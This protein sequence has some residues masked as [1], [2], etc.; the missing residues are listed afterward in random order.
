VLELAESAEVTTPE[1]SLLT[2]ILQQNI[3]SGDD[4]QPPTIRRGVAKDRIVS[5]KD[6]EMRHGRKSSGSRYDGHKAHVAVDTESKVITAVETT[7]PGESDGAQVGK[8]LEETQR[9]TGLPVES[10]LGDCAYSSREAMR[11]AVE[12]GVDLKTRMPSSKSGCFGPEAFE[13]STDGRQARCPAGHG[14][15]RHSTISP[16]GGPGIQHRWSQATCTACPLKERCTSGKSR[17]LFVPPDFHEKRQREAH[18]RS[19]EGLK[20]LRLRVAAEHA[21]ARIKNRGAGLARYFGREKTRAQWLWTAAIANLT[22][23]WGQQQ[24]A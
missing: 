14:S 10:A 15:N 24:A 21:I 23:L 2:Q 16:K 17:S 5:A 6:P 7:S 18:A 12:L 20:E 13:V 4:G 9:I 1:V 8:L 11:Q 3:D 22:L 19:P